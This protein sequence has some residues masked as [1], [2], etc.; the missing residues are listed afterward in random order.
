MVWQAREPAEGSE[1]P[2]AG[3]PELWRWSS[4]L[5]LDAPGARLSCGAEMKARTLL[6]FQSITHSILHPHFLPYL[7]SPGRQE[8]SSP[9]PP[10]LPVDTITWRRGAQPQLAAQPS[11]PCASS[12]GCRESQAQTDTSAGFIP[13]GEQVPRQTGSSHQGSVTRLR[14]SPGGNRCLLHSVGFFPLSTDAGSEVQV[15]LMS[16]RKGRV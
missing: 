1:L 4:S 12:S 6:W 16:V 13:R 10:T 9:G 8:K 5:L 2:R 7:R 11:P 14:H 15:S 3:T